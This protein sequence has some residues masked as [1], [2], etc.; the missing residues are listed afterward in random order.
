MKTRYNAADV[1]VGLFGGSQMTFEESS[2]QMTF[3]GLLRWCPAANSAG[4]V[5]ADPELVGGSSEMFYAALG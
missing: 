3:D 5:F 4:C 1:F 2:E